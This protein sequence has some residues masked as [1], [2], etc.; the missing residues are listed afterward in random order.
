MKHSVAVSLSLS[1]FLLGGC[2][3]FQA[4]GPASP[5][6]QPKPISV[7]VGE[8]WKLTEE[9]PQLTNERTN[10]LPFQTEESLQPSGSNTVTPAEQRKLETPR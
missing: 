3:A 9:A 2:A 1:F 7:Q 6:Y 8:N 10:R 5:P 4:K